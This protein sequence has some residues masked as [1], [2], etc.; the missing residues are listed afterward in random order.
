M[1][2]LIGAAQGNSNNLTANI[3]DTVLPSYVYAE[4]N[5]EVEEGDSTNITILS[6]K[7][8]KKCTLWFFNEE[9]EPIYWM[10][11]PEEAGEHSFP[12]PSGAKYV[13]IWNPTI[14]QALSPL[15][16]NDQP[17]YNFSFYYNYNPWNDLR[18]GLGNH[19][20]RPYDSMLMP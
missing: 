8:C 7:D 9:R 5:R 20:I 1:P 19:N 13:G 17:S 3:F 15:E 18:R 14:N 11:F 16:F 6:K 4:E 12:I 2:A 10:T